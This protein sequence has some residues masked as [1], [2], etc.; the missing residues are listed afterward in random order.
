MSKTATSEAKRI[1]AEMKT[2]L[3]GTD[4][5]GVS[6]GFRR[7]NARWGVKVYPRRTCR[8]KCYRNQEIAA[9]YKLGPGVGEA[10]DVVMKSG[11]IAFCYMTK[12]ASQV[13]EI[14]TYDDYE[15][16]RVEKLENKLRNIGL[17]ARDMHAMNM[18]MFNGRL[19]CIDFGFGYPDVGLHNKLTLGN[20]RPNKANDVLVNTLALVGG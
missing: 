16:L 14:D 2:H 12:I 18:G 5:S 4:D 19:V 17:N 3:S 6:C 1:V 7:I 8:N 10:F 20:I 15:Y 9:K 13:G 11:R